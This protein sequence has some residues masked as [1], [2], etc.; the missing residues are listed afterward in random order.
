M[1]R[2][3]AL[4][5]ATMMMVC[6]FVACD[7]GDEPTPEQPTAPQTTEAPTEAPTTEAPTEVPTED[8]GEPEL[9]DV[10]IDVWE[11][12]A[13]SPQAIAPN[14]KGVGIRFVIPEGGYL[15]ESSVT[16]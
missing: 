4:I 8:N 12:K 10:Y 1:K 11:D 6:V 16:A 13:Q 5:L 14:H 9:V 15:Y 7:G 2:I 3:L